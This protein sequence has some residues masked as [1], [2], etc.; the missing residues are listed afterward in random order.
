MKEKYE[1]AIRYVFLCQFVLAG[2]RRAKAIHNLM[3]DTAP[4]LRKTDGLMQEIISYR[5]VLIT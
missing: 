4:F 1:P 2:N 5:I 3:G